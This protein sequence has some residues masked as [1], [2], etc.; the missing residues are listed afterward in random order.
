L[1]LKLRSEREV[2]VLSASEAIGA[3]D[4]QIL[5]A[6]ISKLFKNGK[7]KIVLDVDHSMDLPLDVLREIAHLDI[8]ARELSGRI[9]LSGFGKEA[10]ARIENL[11]KPPAIP[12]FESVQEAIQFFSPPA[13]SSSAAIPGAKPGAKPGPEVISK[14]A[15][16]VKE[17]ARA[18][19]TPDISELRKRLSDL[20]S[21][22]RTLREQLMG[23]VVVRKTVSD[24]Q[25][26]QE[27]VAALEQE[28]AQVLNQLKGAQK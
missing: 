9:V 8:L 5:R 22:N 12:S 27:K 4:I 23:W 3:A 25:V 13:P 2:Q 24:A 16:G 14:P 6:G 21:E 19:E 17:E 26:Y 18:R 1:K 20:E 10:K 7:N 11:M 15:P 28:L